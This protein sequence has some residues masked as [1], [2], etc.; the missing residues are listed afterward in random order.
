M[1]SVTKGEIEEIKRTV[2]K[3]TI[4]VGI[5]VAA[6][7]LIFAPVLTAAIKDRLR[8]V[9][10]NSKA[11]AQQEVKIEENSRHNA[12]TRTQ[13][14]RCVDKIDQTLREDRAARLQFEGEVRSLLLEAIK[15]RKE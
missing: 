7:V 11:N 4:L 14:Q 12:E 15:E 2:R 8:E 10:D 3:N 13:L 1:A 9:A 6:V 5:G